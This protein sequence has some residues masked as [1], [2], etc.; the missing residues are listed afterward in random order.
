MGHLR[1]NCRVPTDHG[2]IYPERLTLFLEMCLTGETKVG[3]HGGN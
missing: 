1:E 3:N 2:V